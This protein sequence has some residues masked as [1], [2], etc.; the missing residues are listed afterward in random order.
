MRG[1]DC[2]SFFDMVPIALDI[3]NKQLGGQWRLPSQAELTSIVCKEC[4]SPK[5]D[6]RDFSEYGQCPLL[7][8]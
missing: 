8:G 2:K 7:D 1:K 3:A 5:I 4:S 6:M